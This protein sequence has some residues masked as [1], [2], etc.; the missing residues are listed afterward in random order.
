MSRGRPVKADPL[1]IASLKHSGPQ[2][3]HQLAKH[4]GLLKNTCERAVTRLHLSKQI[5]IQS[6]I[7]S[8][9][10]YGPYMALFAI[11][12]DEQ[13]DCLSPK[14]IWDNRKKT[15]PG[16][17]SIKIGRE[18]SN[19]IYKAINGERTAPDIQEFLNLQERNVARHIKKMMDSKRIHICSWRDN[20]TGYFKPVY[21]RGN[22]ESVPYPTKRQRKSIRDPILTKRHDVLK[23]PSVLGDPFGFMIRQMT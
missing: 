19:R 6:W 11:R 8:A 7:K 13:K 17:H 3:R 5:Y 23:G 4:C 10:V 1:V 14:Q 18:N 20:H 12:D 16:A 22:Q 21:A 2:T 15:K 9:S